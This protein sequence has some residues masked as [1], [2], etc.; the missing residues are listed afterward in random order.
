V[1]A[2]LFIVSRQEPELFQYLLQE[3]AS[4]EDV[5]V[6][7]DRRLAERR[8]GAAAGEPDAERRRGERRAQA[9]VDRQLRALGYAFVR[10]ERSRP[11]AGP[12]ATA[13]SGSR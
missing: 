8:R 10:V 3:F 9:H 5:H 1:V 11:L 12:A 7:L 4:E 13:V 6:I 2:H